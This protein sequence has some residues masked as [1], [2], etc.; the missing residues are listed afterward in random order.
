MYIIALHVVRAL[1]P[2]FPTHVHVH[3]VGEAILLPDAEF[4]F[5]CL[6][7]EICLN[8]LA[9]Y[10]FGPCQLSCLGTLVAEDLVVRAECCGLKSHLR[11]PINF[12][13]EKD[14]LRR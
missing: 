11:Q 4:E 2:S 8:C 10:K 9:L 7:D 13:P 1:F 5:T 12:S 6:R 14:F 3:G